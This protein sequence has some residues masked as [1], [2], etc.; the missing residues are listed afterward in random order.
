MESRNL[1]AFPP[2]RQQKNAPVALRRYDRYLWHRK[3]GLSGREAVSKVAEEEDLAEKSIVHELK[4]AQA[5]LR[6]QK[7]RQIQQQRLQ[8]ELENEKLRRKIRRTHAQKVVK[9]VGE[10][11]EGKTEAIYFDEKSGKIV[12]KEYQDRKV[13]LQGLEQYAKLTALEV[14]PAPPS[15]TVVNVETNV[16]ATAGGPGGD[17]EDRMVRLERLRKERTAGKVIDVESN[18]VID[19]KPTEKPSEK[20][21]VKTGE[22][23]WDW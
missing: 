18:P 2:E 13:Q 5:I 21:P 4:R 22:S 14:K 6:V 19:R 10:L 8:A 17:Y 9:V 3:Q 23:P 12:S 11:I 1:P 15:Q 16:T 20:K 7:T